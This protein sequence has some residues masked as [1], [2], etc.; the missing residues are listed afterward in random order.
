M[1]VKQ[2]LIYFTIKPNRVICINF[3]L[4]C[5]SGS[6][7]LTVHAWK[8]Y[9]VANTVVTLGWKLYNPCGYIYTLTLLRKY[10]YLKYTTCL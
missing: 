1:P 3:E 9:N 4:V 8:L 10:Y 5:A 7:L 2:N 6:H